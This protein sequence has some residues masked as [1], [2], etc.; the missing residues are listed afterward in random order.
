M[1][2]YLHFLRHA[3]VLPLSMAQND[4]AAAMSEPTAAQPTLQRQ[5]P[6]FPPAN[7]VNSAAARQLSACQCSGNFAI[8][9]ER[10]LTENF[11]F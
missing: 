6:L 11:Y 3:H 1:Y 10:T 2:L 9:T 5:A 7:S 4:D 8:E